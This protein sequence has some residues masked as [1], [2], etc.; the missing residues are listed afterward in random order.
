MFWLLVLINFIVI[1]VI[2]RTIVGRFMRFMGVDFFGVNVALRFVI[3]LILSLIFA[4][5]EMA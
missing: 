4:A 5:L 3:C 2:V 1:V